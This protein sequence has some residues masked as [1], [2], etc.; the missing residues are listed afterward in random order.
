MA[1]DP[2]DRAAPK[3][4]YE[5]GREH[6]GYSH[7]GIPPGCPACAA[8]RQNAPTASDDRASAALAA[9]RDEA[10]GS[11][12]YAGNHACPDAGSSCSA[13]NALRLLA[14]VERVLELHRK[15]EK[16][17][18]TTRVC[19]EHV[20]ERTRAH[21]RDLPAWREDI[22]ACPDCTV[23]EKYVCAEPSCR[24]ECPDDDEWPCPTVEAIT[25]ALNGQEAGDGLEARS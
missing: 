1:P 12:A 18:R 14:A 13:H 17:V 8:E 5:Y 20:Q 22:A 23:T 16:P 7:V 6:D 24:C 25:E 4:N 3:H 11:I 2:D 21:A 19:P 10:L 15:Q 9:I